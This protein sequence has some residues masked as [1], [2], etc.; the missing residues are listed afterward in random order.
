MKSI[1][2]IFG[3]DQSL[4]KS[5]IELDYGSFSL[6]VARAGGAN[7]Q[8]KRVLEQLAKPYKHAIQRG[9]LDEETQKR[10]LA[11]AY[12]RAVVLNWRGVVDRNGEPMECN[13]ENIVKLLLDLPDLFDSLQEEA[14]KLANFQK[15]EEEDDA[16]N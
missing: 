3:A 6:T 5:G 13:E 8:F 4:E 14:S 12:A 1:Y 7:A 2:D 15:E 16:K 10:I 9:I 11:T